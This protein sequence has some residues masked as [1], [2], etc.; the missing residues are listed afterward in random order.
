MNFGSKSD[1]PSYKEAFCIGPKKKRERM[2][3]RKK[4]NVLH[5]FHVAGNRFGIT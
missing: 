2:K 4:R 5:D 1:G 3:Q